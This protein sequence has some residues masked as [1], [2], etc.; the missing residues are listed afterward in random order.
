MCAC[1]ALVCLAG[2]TA[3]AQGGGDVHIQPRVKPAEAQP[4]IT[5]TDPS[6]KTHTKPMK[7]DVDLV[8]IAD[9]FRGETGLGIEMRLNGC[10]I[11]VLAEFWLHANLLSPLSERQRV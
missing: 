10:D 3:W 6:L 7:V 5:E 9:R 2:S 8:R 11:P 1:L 4:K